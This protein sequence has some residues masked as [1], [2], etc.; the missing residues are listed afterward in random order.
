MTYA[1]EAYINCGYP[2][3]LNHQCPIHQPNCTKQELAI[4]RDVVND[5][6]P[7]HPKLEAQLH[8]RDYSLCFF[9]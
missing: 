8:P 1:G 4:I 9:P 3:A 2:D 7:S 5:Y 6:V